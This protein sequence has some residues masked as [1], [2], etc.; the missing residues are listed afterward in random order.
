M[1]NDA[2]IWD[3]A[4]GIAL[5]LAAGLQ[6]SAKGKNGDWRPFER[7]AGSDQGA[8]S[9]DG[10]RAWRERI[11]AG[12]PKAVQELTRGSARRQGRVARLRR[13]LLGASA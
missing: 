9:V 6:V 10:L 5:C 1:I 7:F 13:S 11:V 8:P 3:V 12:D 4:G 2:K